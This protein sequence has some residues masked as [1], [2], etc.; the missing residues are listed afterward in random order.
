[1]GQIIDEALQ[2]D[3]NAFQVVNNLKVFQCF[4]QQLDLQLAIHIS[5]LFFYV[6]CLNSTQAH[7]IITQFYI[8]IRKLFE[9]LQCLICQILSLFGQIL[10]GKEILIVGQFMDFSEGLQPQQI[11][12]KTACQRGDILWTKMVFAYLKTLVNIANRNKA[13]QQVQEESFFDR[14]RCLT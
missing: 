10:I 14:N 11:C 6:T 2:S 3:L 13:H 9:D 7:S 5:I 12:L 1:M 8:F 4:S